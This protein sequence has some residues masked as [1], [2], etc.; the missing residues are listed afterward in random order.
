MTS[1]ASHTHAGRREISAAQRWRLLAPA[2]GALLLLSLCVLYVLNGY[3]TI[4]SMDADA[5]AQGKAIISGPGD[6][7]HRDIPQALAMATGSWYDDGSYIGEVHWYPFM[8][9]LVVAWYMV[10]TG[11]PLQSA[12]RIG[13]MLISMASLPALAWLLSRY[14]GRLAYLALAA[15]LLLALYWPS[16]SNYPAGSSMAA[17]FL[18]LG[19]AASAFERVGAARC[20]GWMFAAG[21]SAGWLAL[22][23]GASFITASAVVA[24]LMGFRVLAR[25]GEQRWRALGDPALAAAG[26]A[27]GCAPLFLPQLLRYG[28]LQQADVARLFIN[29]VLYGDGKNTAA[30]LQ[31][32]LLPKGLD[33]ALPALFLITLAVAR[34][35]RMWLRSA[36]LLISYVLGVGLG[37]LGFIM[38]GA[39]FPWLV[40][41]ANRFIPSPPH[42]FAWIAITVLI[43]ARCVAVALL[44]FYGVAGLR[45]AARRW[46]WQPPQWLL[47]TL[48]SAAMVGGYAWLLGH[49]PSQGTGHIEYADQELFQFAEGVSRIAGPQRS[50]YT[51]SWA[52]QREI[53]DLMPFKVPLLH[54]PLHSNPYLDQQHVQDEYYLGTPPRF[55]SSFSEVIERNHVGYALTMPGELNVTAQLCGGQPVLRSAQGYTLWQLHPPCRV[56]TFSAAQTSAPDDRLGLIASE[57][58]A[59]LTIQGLKPGAAQSFVSF[60]AV[61]VRGGEIVSLTFTGRMSGPAAES[62]LTPQADFLSGGRPDGTMFVNFSY[63]ADGQIALQFWLAT[64][65]STTTITPKL[66][67]RSSCFDHGQSIVVENIRVAHEAAHH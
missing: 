56:P 23:H 21:L 52:G 41:L 43:A 11:E 59:G 27:L 7:A 2:A 29:P 48:L 61:D 16:N 25:W 57:S 19:L 14:V 13:C 30:F 6:P 36:P 5:A 26:L 17:F 33:A 8:T 34:S 40:A 58:A 24:A 60:P 22:W 53:F 62:C 4:R 37:Q 50:V 66:G 54:S 35:R 64:P 9:P 32:E 15:A 45:W 20:N 10:A 3:A 49:M 47:P 12:Y 42:T 38:N 51:A 65:V 1:L 31:L 44:L 55:A 18:F 67:F 63:P 46:A 39:D 28:H